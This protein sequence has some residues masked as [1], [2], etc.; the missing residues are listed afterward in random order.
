MH[1]TRQLQD[2]MWTVPPLLNGPQMHMSNSLASSRA[3][4]ISDGMR[5]G[6]D[7][8]PHHA[9]ISQE[10]NATPEVAGMGFAGPA[11]SDCN[12]NEV[13]YGFEYP[14]L[15]LRCSLLCTA[16]IRFSFLPLLGLNVLPGLT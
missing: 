11:M 16:E 3:T 9:L 1:D 5:A 6:G 7:E 4:G 8:E 10:R 14:P 12:T 15:E 2:D 13:R